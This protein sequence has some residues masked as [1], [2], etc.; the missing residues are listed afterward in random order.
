M[1]LQSAE[2]VD[3][4]FCTIIDILD[5]DLEG[6][7]SGPEPAEPTARSN[8]DDGLFDDGPA[9][10]ILPTADA[11]EPAAEGDSDEMEDRKEKKHKK[12][13]KRQERQEGQEGQEGGEEGQAG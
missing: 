4:A 5:D 8:L 10:P 7:E 3:A 6:E 1:H 11:G 13:K 12:D 2:T 9:E